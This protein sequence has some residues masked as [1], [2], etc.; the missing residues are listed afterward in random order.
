MLSDR[1]LLVYREYGEGCSLWGGCVLGK[2]ESF[3]YDET[4]LRSPSAAAVRFAFR[5][6]KILILR[7]RRLRI[8]T[9]CSLR[10]RGEA[11]CASRPCGQLGHFGNSLAFEFRVGLAGWFLP[12]KAFPRRGRAT[13][14]LPFRSLAWRSSLGLLGRRRLISAFPRDCLWRA[15]RARSAYVTTA[16]TCAMN[17]A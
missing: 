5:C 14:I 4:Y 2:E 9:V 7:G 16:M 13:A 8:S 11:F 15:R 3:S 6:A 17:G 12:K 1:S 10:D